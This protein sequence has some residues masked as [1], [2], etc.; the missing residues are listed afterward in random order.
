M[1]ILNVKGAGIFIGVLVIFQVAFGMVLSPI[2]GKIIVENVNKHSAAK[3]DIGKV[4]VWPLTLSASMSNLKVFDPDSTSESMAR[5][6]K[7]SIRVSLLRLL[8]KQIVVSRLSI[9]GAEIDVK[10]EP[11]GSFNVQK[12]AQ[13]DEKKKSSRGDL[14]SKK[15]WFS[16]IYSMIKS[17]TSKEAVAE[18]KEAQV[19]AN[20]IKKD[21]EALP[22]GRRVFF[23]TLSDEYVFQIKDLVIKNSRIDLAPSSGE[24]IVLDRASVVIKNLGVDPTR[25]ARFDVMKVSGRLES[26][27]E[28][29][30]SFDL[31]YSQ[32]LKND[33]QYINCT[34]SAKD[35]DLAATGFIYKDSLP[36]SFSKGKISINSTTNIVNEELNSK[37][38]LSLRGQNVSPSGGNAMIGMVPL[39]AICEALNQV[40]PAKFKF[41]ITGTTSNPKFEGFQESLMDLVK[42]YLANQIKEQ[43]LKAL[44]N[45]FKKEAGETSVSSGAENNTAKEAIKS[46]SSLFG[47][48][49]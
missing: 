33:K 32:S 44:G 30:G 19:S 40:D 13:T 39:S 48:K 47:N 34:I 45:V 42:P 10:T 31:N 8:A 9:S 1:K 37:N 11:D 3:I 5:V 16:K 29:A 43:G 36:V 23:K 27:G 46:I 38:S 18:D 7:A 17:K 41:E 24:G 15:D 28:N 22:K 6:K 49:E 25:G 2:L 21:V 12:L 20:K 14:R 26:N 35:I 4:N